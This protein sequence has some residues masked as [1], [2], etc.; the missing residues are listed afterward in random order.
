MIALAQHKSSLFGILMIHFFFFAIFSQAIRSGLLRS[1]AP[2]R[3]SLF[4][5]VGSAK[6][7]SLSGSTTS[8]LN[9]LKRRV[10]TLDY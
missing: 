5:N 1:K 8:A 4:T 2:A 6:K 9:L 7:P 3:P 10:R